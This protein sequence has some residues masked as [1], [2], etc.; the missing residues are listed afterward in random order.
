[1][2]RATV[3][4]GSLISAHFFF[5]FDTPSSTSCLCAL[6]KSLLIEMWHKK[7]LERVEIINTLVLLDGK[8]DIEYRDSNAGW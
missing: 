7:D 4:Y 8:E 2:L 3:N 1:M 5:I 6:R